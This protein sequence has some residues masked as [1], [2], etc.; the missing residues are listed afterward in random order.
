MNKH[1]NLSKLEKIINNSAKTKEEKE[2]L[3]KIVEEIVHHKVMNC[4]LD[5]LD[6]HHHE[7]F[8]DK[9]SKYSISEFSENIVEYLEEKSNKK[10]SDE[11][12]KTISKIE[13]EILKELN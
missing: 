1:L 6:R 5:N 11:I 13:T 4:I 2:E 9:F 7:E 12:R 8:L 3:W 10:I